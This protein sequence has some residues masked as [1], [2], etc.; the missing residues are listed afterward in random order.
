MQE[1]K[2]NEQNFELEEKI[3]ILERQLKEKNSSNKM[4]LYE[5]ARI[6]NLLT[7]K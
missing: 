1:F 6:K 4:L 3:A 7:E 5:Q 2:L